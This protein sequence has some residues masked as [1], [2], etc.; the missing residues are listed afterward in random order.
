MR[1][2]ITFG[3]DVLNDYFSRRVDTGEFKLFSIVENIRQPA[4]GFVGPN[5]N[6]GIA[7]LSARLPEQLQRR[8]IF[9]RFRCTAVTDPS[10][11]DPIENTF[12]VRVIERHNPSGKASTRRKPPTDEE[13]NDR[14]IP[15]G[16]AMPKITEV[17][18]ANWHVY[19]PEF[20]KYTALRIKHATTEGEGSEEI[21][22]YD[23]FVNTDNVYLKS[24]MKSSG[25]DGRVTKRPLHLWAG[26][27][28]L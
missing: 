17:P 24:E 4:T 9:S 10:R 12:S 23:F 20:D 26:A 5:L 11:I 6:N 14:E 8:A 18:E 1:C 13:G 16:I 28:R 21:D 19:N 2:R 25:N 22:I 15:A 3:T 27:R 7:T